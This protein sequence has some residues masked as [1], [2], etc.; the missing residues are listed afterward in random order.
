MLPSTHI[1]PAT[2]LTPQHTPSNNTIPP[3]LYPL[4]IHQ[5]SPARPVGRAIAVLNADRVLALPRAPSHEPCTRET[6]ALKESAAISSKSTILTV[7]RSS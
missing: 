7:T 6:C 3:T 4:R 1:F 5:K 2:L